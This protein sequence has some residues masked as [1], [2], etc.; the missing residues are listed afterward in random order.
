MKRRLRRHIAYRNASKAIARRLDLFL[1]AWRPA[2][3]LRGP[4]GTRWSD[5]TADPLE[6]LMRA[7]RAF[8]AI[9]RWSEEESTFRALAPVPVLVAPPEPYVFI[10]SVA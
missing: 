6:D 1:A 8:D 4:A 10:P 9:G 7:K 2:C 5:P 3:R